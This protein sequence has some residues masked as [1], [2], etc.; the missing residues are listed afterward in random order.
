MDRLRYRYQEAPKVYQ[1]LKDY[2]DEDTIVYVPNHRGC[3]VCGQGAGFSG[4]TLVSEL[5]QVNTKVEEMIVQG[6]SPAKIREETLGT[7][8]FEMWEHAM[9]LVRDG[10]ISFDSAI[11][12]LGDRE[13]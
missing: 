5:L 3:D 13:R 2:P 10:V 1:S 12:G 9:T 6:S 7:D 11:N 4:R 8:Y